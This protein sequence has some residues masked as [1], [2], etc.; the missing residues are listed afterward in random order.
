[1]LLALV[2]PAASRAL[3]RSRQTA[4]LSN[5]RQL[6]LAVVAYTQ[7]HDDFYPYGGDAIDI[8]TDAWARGENGRYAEEARRLRPLPEVM[9]KYVGDPDLWRCPMDRGFLRTG[10]WDEVSLRAHPSG[11]AAFGMSY[12][13]R[14]ELTL[15]RR[16]NIAAYDRRPPYT[17]HEA[18]DIYVLFDATGAWHGGRARAEGRWNALMADGHAVSLPLDRFEAAAHLSTAPPGSLRTKP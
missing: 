13:Y 5:L 8:H 14:T 16:R 7:D 6:G 1:M 9:A 4:C 12:L 17:R 15:R 18:P 11:Y 3:N 2:M 10:A